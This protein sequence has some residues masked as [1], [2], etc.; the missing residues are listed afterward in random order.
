MEYAPKCGPVSTKILPVV[1][2]TVMH[3]V[4]NGFLCRLK[5][6]KN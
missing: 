1:Q 5:I 2:C 3:D 6:P 4:C